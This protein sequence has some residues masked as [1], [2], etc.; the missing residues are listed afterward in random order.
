MLKSLVKE[1]QGKGMAVAMADV[2]TPVRE[3]SRKTGLLELIGEDHLFPTVDLAVRS[4]EATV[5]PQRRVTKDSP[6]GPDND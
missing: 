2:H 6:Q 4:M 1:L 3:F 5:A